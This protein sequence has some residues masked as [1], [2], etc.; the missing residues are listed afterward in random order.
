MS[1]VETLTRTERDVVMTDLVGY[2]AQVL[3][4]ETVEVLQVGP[5]SKLFVEL[6][7]NSIDMVRLIEL[8]DEKYPVGEQLVRWGADLNVVSLLRVTL[9]DVAD[10]I[11]HAMG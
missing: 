8:V 1:R 2:V 6:G 7:I 5:R 10:V 3:G 4:A 9:A 11:C